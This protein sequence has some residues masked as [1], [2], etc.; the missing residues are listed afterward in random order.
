MKNKLAIAVALFS[1]F[2]ILLFSCSKG[3]GE[4]PPPPPPP[5]PTGGSSCS[6]T[7]G[8]LFSAARDVIRNNCAVSGCHTGSNA[9]SGINFSDDCQIVSQKGRIKIRAIDGVPTPM[10]PSGL[11]PA[12]ERNKITEWLNAGGT[13]AN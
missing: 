3:G 10:P 12:S 4:S 6:G 9:Q 8:P 2:F 7:P 1:L 5:P 11:L 13:F